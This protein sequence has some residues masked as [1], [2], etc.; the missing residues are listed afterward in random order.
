[1]SQLSDQEVTDLALTLF[2]LQTLANPIDLF[3]KNL[4]TF[5]NIRIEKKV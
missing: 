2:P 5:Y 1:M 3:Y 4:W